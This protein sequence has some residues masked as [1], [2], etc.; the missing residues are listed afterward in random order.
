MKD[1]IKRSVAT[2]L[3]HIIKMDRRDIEENAPLFCKLMKED[4]D[5]NPEDARKFLEQAIEQEYDIDEH[6]EVINRA[7]CDDKLS[8]MHIMDQF[9]HII[10][11]GKIGDR[12]YEEFERIKN[13]LFA[14][15]RN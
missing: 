14:E 3:A 1:T 2:L 8:K 12:D 15:C 4:F 10:Y 9:N 7:L 6:L 13:K 11:S 5:C